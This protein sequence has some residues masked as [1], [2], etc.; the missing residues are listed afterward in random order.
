[1]KNDLNLLNDALWRIESAFDTHPQ[2]Y[3]RIREFG[4][5][6]RDLM[7]AIR[8]LGATAGVMIVDHS[9]RKNPAH[10]PLDYLDAADRLLASFHELVSD[11]EKTAAYA[12]AKL[13]V[14][15]LMRKARE[16]LV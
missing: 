12:A 9:N 2:F 1:M 13:E 7:T 5:L 14:D 3:Q 6:M 10:G 16:A 15:Q 11:D 4:P 8:K